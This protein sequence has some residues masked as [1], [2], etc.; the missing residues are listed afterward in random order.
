MTDRTVPLGT[1]VWW[2][3]VQTVDDIIEDAQA[4]PGFVTIPRGA[5]DPKE[6]R[7][8]KG[9]IDFGSLSSDPSGPVPVLGEHTAAVLKEAGISDE[10]AA[11]ILKQAVK[12][13]ARL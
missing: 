4:Q 9:P 2:Q 11:T 6:I 7:S 1:Q 12:A 10:E 8:V 13:R 3:P 5:Q